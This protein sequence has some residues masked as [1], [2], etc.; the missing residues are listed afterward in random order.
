MPAKAMTR[1]TRTFA[2]RMF[3]KLHAC[4]RAPRQG[5][6]VAL[7]KKRAKKATAEKDVSL[8]ARIEARLRCAVCHLACAVCGLACA[9]MHCVPSGMRWCAIWHALV[10]HLACAVCG[11]ACDGMHCVPSGM[12]CVR[13]GMRWHVL[14][15][16]APGSDGQLL[17]G[18]AR[19]GATTRQGCAAGRAAPFAACLTS[20]HLLPASV[21]CTLPLPP[22]QPHCS[23][24]H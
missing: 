23:T 21:P 22:P 24:A 9:G 20:L 14:V 2:W 19:C 8:D 3:Y 11:L 15:R 4:A 12:R 16:C 13:S 6:N 18:A 7:Q 1:S 5:T 10:C 17:R